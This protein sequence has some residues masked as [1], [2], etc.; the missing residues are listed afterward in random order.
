MGCDEASII[1][2]ASNENP[3][4]V[5][6][7]RAARDRARGRRS[8]ALSGR[9]R[10]R[11][12]A[13]AVQTLRRG[14]PEQI[15][16]GNGSNDV[17]ELAARAFLTPGSRGDLLAACVRGLSAG[18][19]G[20]GREGH[21]GRG[22]GLRPRS[23]RHAARRDEEDAASCSSPIRTIRR[24]RWSRRKSSRRS[25]SAAAG[26]A[27]GARRG[28]QRVPAGGLRADSIAWLRAVSQP[29]RDAHFFQ[30]LRSGGP[31]RGLRV[32]RAAASPI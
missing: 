8:R 12:E 17:L 13:G 7:L 21:R 14:D 22:Q 11:A 28:L 25:C 26:S 10:L 29:G 27:G 18:G 16:L 31:A 1:K 20:D 15:V 24:A 4:G 23:R 2:L 9:Q 3:L 30:G 6:P 5:S 32:R 19:A